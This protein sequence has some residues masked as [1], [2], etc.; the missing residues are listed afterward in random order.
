MTE[1]SFSLVQNFG[2]QPEDLYNAL[3]REVVMTMWLGDRVDVNPIAGG[4]FYCYW[5]GAYTVTGKYLELV[6]NEKLVLEWKGTD[7]PAASKVEFLIDGGKLSLTHSGI[8]S[9]WGDTFENLKTGWEAALNRL[10]WVINKGVDERA[11]GR[12]FMG[13]L[14]GN[15]LDE[16]LAQSLEVPVSEGVSITG[17]VDDTGAA[18]SG[19]QADDVI[20]KFAET[21]IKNYQSFAT[22]VAPYKPG[23]MVDLVVYRKNEKLTIP[24]ELSQRPL[25][26]A[27]ETLKDLISSLEAEYEKIDAEI[28]EIFD[29]TT[30]ENA[31]KK[32]DE[33]EWSALE[34]MAHLI[35]TERWLHFN[36]ANI[37]D[38]QVPPA[39]VNNDH[40]LKGLADSF[41][42]IQDM[43]DALKQDEKI[44]LQIC[45]NL[46]P[47]IV[48]RKYQYIALGDGLIRG[49]PGHTRSHYDQLR[50]ALK[51][52]DS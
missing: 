47:E 22:A 40:H 18:A 17:T 42:T 4:N 15:I 48:D 43:L 24:V 14:L 13:I 5:D 26:Q 33:H 30:E 19:L 7:E 2:C 41:N 20:V 16:K 28:A 46:P 6:E 32:P 23:D 52:A 44:S 25:P 34:T 1:R 8:G 51:S 21:E 37:L 27:P 3:T 10:D 36:L 11:F 29:G 35:Y 49:F 9:D 12:P 45:K 39:F 50:E 31:R 38:Y